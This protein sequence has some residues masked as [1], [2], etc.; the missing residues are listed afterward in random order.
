VRAS[1]GLSPMTASLPTASATPTFIRVA[2]WAFVIRYRGSAERR[3][4]R[5]DGISLYGR[6]AS[7][8]HRK[9][10]RSVERRELVLA[11]ASG[12]TFAQA[13]ARHSDP[14]FDFVVEGHRIPPKVQAAGERLQAFP[15]LVVDEA[16]HL[17]MDSG[18]KKVLPTGHAFNLPANFLSYFLRR[19]ARHRPA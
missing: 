17:K 18:S 11:E 19:K 16:A 1:A 14:S 9:P 2:L 4:E 6:M 10:K 5:R 3:L 7:A 8:L 15:R 12:L 13:D